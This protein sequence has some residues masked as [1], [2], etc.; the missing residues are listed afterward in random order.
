MSWK[1]L[2]T[3]GLFCL[4][5]SPAFAQPNMGIV[6]TGGTTGTGGSNGHLNATGNWIWTV[7]VTPA[8][9]MVPDTS[10]TPVAIEA[11]F[12]STSTGVGT[13]TTGPGNG[14]NQGA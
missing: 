2:V 3:A 9:T 1:S 11:G 5:A 7:Q 10:G 8:L 14:F 6:S 12:T 13:V 4:L